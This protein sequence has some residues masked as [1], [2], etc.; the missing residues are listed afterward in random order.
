[1]VVNVHPLISELHLLMKSITVE[2]MTTI[3]VTNVLNKE[4]LQYH[5]QRSFGPQSRSMSTSASFS[6][7]TSVNS[8]MI[9]NKLSIATGTGGPSHYLDMYDIVLMLSAT[10]H[11]ISTAAAMANE[12][13]IVSQDS[14]QASQQQGPLVQ[15]TKIEIGKLSV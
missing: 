12:G 14:T 3:L 8:M 10:S 4:H 15:E 6:A 5:R 2:A 13:V 9:T 11:T 7:H 1:M